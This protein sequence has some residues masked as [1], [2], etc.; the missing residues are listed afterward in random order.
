MS[1]IDNIL[2]PVVSAFVK[3]VGATYGSFTENYVAKKIP[4]QLTMMIFT[5]GI[6]GAHTLPNDIISIRTGLDQKTT[7]M[8][9]LHE[10]GHWSGCI[11]RAE[12]DFMVTTQLA[13]Q[14][15]IR[16]FIITDNA[17]EEVTAQM[18]AMGLATYL[19]LDHAF[20]IDFLNQVLACYPAADLNKAKSDSERAIDFLINLAEAQ[21][22]A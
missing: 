9:M 22:A 17:T 8:V 13:S 19:G 1:E 21:K 14:N 3:Q 6:A 15:K 4:R 12:R 18:C 5:H 20:H 11:G 2:S 10:L 7:D 16:G